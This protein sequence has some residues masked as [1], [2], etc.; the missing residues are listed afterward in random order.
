MKTATDHNFKE[1]MMLIFPNDNSK[2][3]AVV[4]GKDLEKVY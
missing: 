2:S 3:E 4:D 1:S